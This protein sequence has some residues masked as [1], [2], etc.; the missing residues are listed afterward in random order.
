MS[1][2]AISVLKS[3]PSSFAV[4]FVHARAGHHAEHLQN[5]EDGEMMIGVSFSSGN[6]ATGND[7]CSGAGLD[8]LTSLTAAMRTAM[9]VRIDRLVGMRAHSNAPAFVVCGAGAL[10]MC[11]GSPQ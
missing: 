8:V 7:S 10:V 1:S 9:P 5:V 11:C 3:P 6:D 4:R 2:E